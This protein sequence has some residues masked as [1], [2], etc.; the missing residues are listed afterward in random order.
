MLDFAFPLAAA[1]QYGWGQEGI[2][3]SEK[4]PFLFFSFWYCVHCTGIEPLD[5]STTGFTA[6]YL[7]SYCELFNNTIKLSKVVIYGSFDVE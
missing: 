5:T 2:S 6:K 4:E 1:F 3:R 7:K